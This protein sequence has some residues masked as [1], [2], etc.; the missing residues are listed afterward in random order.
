[1]SYARFFENEVGD[2]EL[3]KDLVIDMEKLTEEQKAMVVAWLAK[4]HSE[5]VAMERLKTVL[6]QAVFDLTAAELGAML[7][8]AGNA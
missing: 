4:Q 1:M 5:S 3:P 2:K 7:H 6:Q 8:Q